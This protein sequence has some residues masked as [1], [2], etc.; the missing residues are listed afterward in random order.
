MATM[1][2]HERRIDRAGETRMTAP[3]NCHFD[4]TRGLW[5]DLNGVP[6]AV[7]KDCEYDDDHGITTWPDRHGLCAF[8][9]APPGH[10]SQL[11]RL[12]PGDVIL[13][14]AYRLH[15]ESLDTFRL[16]VTRD[17]IA[18]SSFFE[19]EVIVVAGA[20]QTSD[21]TETERLECFPVYRQLADLPEVE[22]IAFFSWKR[23]QLHKGMPEWIAAFAAAS[24][25]LP[26]FSLPVPPPVP[27]SARRRRIFYE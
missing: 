17:I 6:F 18:L 4:S 19:C 14:P 21:M 22:G 23:A 5:L 9:Y 13:T 15:G 16:R 25:D 24:P 3:G 12:L 1:W 20:G 11:D 7:W 27:Q 26:D 8:A 2:T 10:R